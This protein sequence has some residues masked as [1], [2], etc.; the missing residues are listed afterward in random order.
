MLLRSSV[1][2]NLRHPITHHRWSGSINKFVFF[3]FSTFL[4]PFV[5]EIFIM[6]MSL[7]LEPDQLW[8][9]QPTRARTN[10]YDLANC[11]SASLPLLHLSGR[12]G[13][14]RRVRHVIGRLGSPVCRLYAGTKCL[15]EHHLQKGEEVFTMILQ[16]RGTGSTGST[17]HLDQLQY[18][19][20][21]VHHRHN[22]EIS[23]T[24]I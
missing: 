16:P 18:C 24:D 20:N 23:T 10:W 1:V 7:R 5:E 9:P 11:P 21:M 12:C 15:Q 19:S 4:Q 2:S 3:S 8:F 17:E 22:H 13:S 14:A 6:S